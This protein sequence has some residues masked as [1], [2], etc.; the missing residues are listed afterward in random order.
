L[1]RFQKALIRNMPIKQAGATLI[2]LTIA[3][4]IASVLFTITISR[5]GGFID[6]IEV[7]GAVTEIA[8]LFSL[9]RHAAIS[10]G[11]QSVLSIDAAT[12]TVAVRVGTELVRSRDVGEA[13]GVVLT[14][15][16]SSITYSPIGVGYGAA[17]FSL[18]V[19]RGAVADTIVV[20]R[21]GRV[22]H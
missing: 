15:N 18:V 6:A 20:S 3:L 12:G 5:A 7:R 2:E 9:A 11:A 4:A 19:R 13:H 1:V 16:R 10:R 14:T 21:L 17:N 8:S 22:R